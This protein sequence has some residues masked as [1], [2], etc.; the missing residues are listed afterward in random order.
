MPY[1]TFYRDI[2]SK[3]IVCLGVARAWRGG[4]LITG[5]RRLDC[6]KGHAQSLLPDLT[7]SYPPFGRPLNTNQPNHL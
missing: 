3:F 4:P 2:R 1:V 7:P 6:Y 5:D